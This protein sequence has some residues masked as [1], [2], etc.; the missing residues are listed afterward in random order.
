MLEKVTFNDLLAVLDP[1]RI[2]AARTRPKAGVPQ[3]VTQPATKFDELTIDWSL[4]ANT[5][6]RIFTGLFSLSAAVEGGTVE[7]SL[8]VAES[9]LSES[10]KTV[11]YSTGWQRRLTG[12]IKDVLAHHQR[13]CEKLQDWKQQKGLPDEIAEQ[14][15]LTAPWA[16]DI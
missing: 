12:A 1:L 10:Y 9:A 2:D 7:V 3:S 11:Q 6:L 4:D 13:E 15:R 5:L 8:Y 14:R 16:D